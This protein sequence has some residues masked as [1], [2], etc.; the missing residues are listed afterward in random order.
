MGRFALRAYRPID[1]A[2][3]EREH[4]LIGFAAAGGIPVPQPVQLPDG[5]TILE[6]D[7]RFYALFEWARG[8]QLERPR[9]GVGEA[10]AC[11]RVLGR[12][13]E[14]L[15]GY[16]LAAVA[17]RSVTSAAPTDRSQTVA[18]LD[19]LEAVIRARPSLDPMDDHVLNHLGGRRR[20]LERSSGD[21]VSLDGI[22]IQPL[23]GDFQESNL[24]FGAGQVS[25]VIDWDEAHGGRRAWELIR[26][27]HLM[28]KFEPELCRAFWLGYDAS[29]PMR[30]EEL[31]QVAAAYAEMRVHD[32]WAYR[33]IYDEGDDRVRRFFSP[34]TGGFVPLTERWARLRPHLVGC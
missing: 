2:H 28:L 22:P 21:V 33:A 7:A 12:I 5:G 25:A 4:A 14:R 13:H 18:E 23:H 30:F 26:A 19:R 31:D 24:F 17:T 29:L 11:G 9:L 20:W 34:G 6:R 3:V 8:S 1:R 15:R 16:P 32:L 27:I 10:A